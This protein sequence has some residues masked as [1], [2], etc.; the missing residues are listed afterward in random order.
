[1]K[2]NL[3]PA[4]CTMQSHKQLDRAKLESQRGDALVNLGV[5]LMLIIL[6][7][8]MGM[9]AIKGWVIEGRTPEVAGEMQRLMARL[10]V[11]GETGT[12]APY[13]NI[14]NE[15]NLIPALRGSSVVRVDE[16]ANTIAHR[17]GGRGNGTN[18]TIVLAPAQYESYGMGSAYQLTFTNVHD[19]ACPTLAS[20]LSQM[21]E[22]ITIN[23]NVVKDNRESAID[24]TYNA[25]D[26]QTHC[27]D[28]EENTFVFMGR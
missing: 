26:A 20:I 17:L 12:A 6:L 3:A 4:P 24:T 9:P 5:A 14:A 27:E 21:A 25:I 19:K 8:I 2:K 22:R 1:M 7:A 23:G 18:G 28:G 15:T 10:N 11:M 13:A 16:D